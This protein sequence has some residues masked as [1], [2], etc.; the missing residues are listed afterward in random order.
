MYENIG[1]F[2]CCS[3]FFEYHSYPCITSIYSATSSSILLSPN[4]FNPPVAGPSPYLLVHSLL[5]QGFFRFLCCH[6][7]CLSFCQKAPLLW[8]LQIPQVIG[9]AAA[10][11]PAAAVSNTIHIFIIM[12]PK[13]PLSYT[14]N[15]V[16]GNWNGGMVHICLKLAAESAT[17]SLQTSGRF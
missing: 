6:S 5:A 13:A 2:F 15:W 1:T 12:D 8:Y 17:A 4:R 14:Y 7:R 9:S 16:C 3:K 11:A 10:A